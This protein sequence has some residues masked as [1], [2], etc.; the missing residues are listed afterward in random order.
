VNNRHSFQVLKDTIQSK[1]KYFKTRTPFCVEKYFQKFQD[2][3]RSWRLAFQGHS[4]KQGKL[5]CKEKV[6][7]RFLA[8]ADFVCDEAPVTVGIVRD[9]S[10]RMLCYSVVADGFLPF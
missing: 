10:S 2:L 3:L 5:N 4:I 1:T 8:D 9:R 6:D 7:S